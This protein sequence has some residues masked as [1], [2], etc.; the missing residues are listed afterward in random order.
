VG[1]REFAIVQ[2]SGFATMLTTRADNLTASQAT[3]M[4]RLPRITLSGNYP[5]L[6]SLRMADSGLTAWRE[7]RRALR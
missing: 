5:A 6:K 4:D 3:Q 7:K 1:E 2:R